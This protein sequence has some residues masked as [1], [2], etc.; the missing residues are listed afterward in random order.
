[1]RK[2]SESGQK[3]LNCYYFSRRIVKMSHTFPTTS[4]IHCFNRRAMALRWFF[5]MVAQCISPSK[6]CK[7]RLCVTKTSDLKGMSKDWNSVM[8]QPPVPA[9]ISK[10][11]SPDQTLWERNYLL[12]SSARLKILGSTSP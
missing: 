3:P 4:N 12:C 2:H 8:V 6:L 11:S 10:I 9:R 1:M 7:T 5:G